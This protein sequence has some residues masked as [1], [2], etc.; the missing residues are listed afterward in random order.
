LSGG[1][2]AVDTLITNRGKH[3][4][5]IPAGLA[6]GKYLL[7]GEI[8]AL[9]EADTAFNVNSARGAQFYMECIQ[10]NVTGAGAT[11]RVFTILP[12][13]ISLTFA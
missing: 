10:I 8:I 9:H 12:S 7:R 4:V 1:T 13:N 5:T 11:V 2:W 3:D 6:P